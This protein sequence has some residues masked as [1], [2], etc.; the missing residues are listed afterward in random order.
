MNLNPPVMPSYST[1]VCEPI[2]PANM[3]Q[4]KF[5]PDWYHFLQLMREAMIS[6]P[7]LDLQRDFGA[8]M[9]GSDDTGPYQTAINTLVSRGGGTL[10]IPAGT[11]STF[12]VGVPANAPPI[13]VAGQGDATIHKRRG[14]LSPGKG[15]LDI[16][17][18]NFFLSNL[19]MDGATTAPTGLQYNKDFMGIGGLNDPYAA[20]LTNNT[21]L[22]L[23]GGASNLNLQFVKFQHAAGYS[24]L[25][26]ATQNTIRDI[27]IERCR[28][29]NNRPTLFGTTPGQ[30][31]YGS[32]NG[33]IFAK[34]DGRTVG[35][36]AVKGLLV[37]RCH[38]E[39]NTGN[40]T[41][42]HQWGLNELHEDFRIDTC[43]FEDCGLDGVLMGVV[44]GGHVKGCVFTRIGYTTVD[45]TSRSVPRWLSGL[46]ATALDSSGIVKGVPYQGNTFRSV[47]GGCL[48]LD[49]HGESSI[50]GNVCRIPYP[51]EPEYLI[52]QIAIT[53]LNNNGSDGY[54]LNMSNTSQVAE[55]ASDVVIVANE[56]TNL[57]AGAIRMYAAR[58]V[59]CRSNG[60]E[61]PP[62]SIVAPIT[63]GPIGPGPNQRCY[64]NRVSGNDIDYNPPSGAPAIVED[65]TYSQFLGTEV[66]TVCG[67]TPIT[68]SGTLATEFQKSIHSGSVHYSEQVWF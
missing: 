12:S 59:R 1:P 27:H 3:A 24:V 33:G 19:V 47:N 55:G 36:G 66:N 29:F 60:I 38:F 22:W 37:S 64:D 61:A 49:G 15:L 67:N 57:N 32:W 31:I 54:G 42:S 50:S 35:S 65:D 7:P 18:S 14:S 63:M 2:T 39:R 13:F 6:F 46:N 56:F 40:C 58:R 44:S 30:L 41:W 16:L 8:R 23:H 11:L 9:D 28:L 43:F 52:D 68:P 10:T 51:D 25:L 53:G 45:D 17:A 4:V 34:G 26:D 5:D 20:S 62:N 48:D 21:T